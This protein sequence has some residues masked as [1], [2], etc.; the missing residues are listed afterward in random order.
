[1][2]FTIFLGAFGREERELTAEHMSG[3]CIRESTLVGILATGWAALL[4]GVGDTDGFS[5]S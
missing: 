1:M 3:S 4:V 5:F 2:S